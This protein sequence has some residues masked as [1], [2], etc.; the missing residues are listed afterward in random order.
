MVYLLQ[1]RFD[2]QF[3]Q[4]ADTR[5]IVIAAIVVGAFVIILLIAGAVTGRGKRT[6]GGS[7]AKKYSRGGFRRRAKQLGLT[8]AHISTLEYVK[9]KYAVKSPMSLLSN[10]PQLDYYLSKAVRDIDAQV[11]SAET[12]EAQKLTLYRIKQ[13]I[14]RNAQKSGAIASTKQLKPNQRLTVSSEGGE[15]YPS[16]VV[17]ILKDGLAM[18]VP[19]VAGSG[20]VRWKKWATVTVFFWKANGEGFSFESKITGYNTFKGTQ[21]V[22]VQHS[23]K[24]ASAKQRRFRRKILEG[25]CYFYPV[26]VLTMGNGRNK[27]KKAFVETKKASLGTI[28]EISAGGCSIRGSRAL[29]KGALIKVD[30]ETE[31]SVSISS[32]G[33][34][35]NVSKESAIN[36]VMH[37]MFTRVSKKNL[38]RINSYVYDY[39]ETS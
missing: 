28:I 10:S 17:G 20:Q 8:K 3:V 9:D 36:T 5:T 22:F 38:N 19:E 12:Q 11:A 29:P 21:S 31:R 14:E 18:E 37:I 15:R 2:T 32:Y 13:V 23:N 7:G 34:V 39:G 33:K 1:S 6:G 26:R 16:R 35:V 24:I 4:K 25:P 27:Q 30:F